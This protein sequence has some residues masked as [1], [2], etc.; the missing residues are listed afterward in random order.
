V[1]RVQRPDF[2]TGRMFSEVQD[3]SDLM[4]IRLMS[5]FQYLNGVS[6]N[7]LTYSF[8]VPT[9]CETLKMCSHT[10]EGAGM[11]EPVSSLSYMLYVAGSRDLQSDQTCFGAHLS[12]IR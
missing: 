6:R 4:G 2:V 8:P 7:N 5:I 3:C 9:C 11:G 1:G 12:P 10:A